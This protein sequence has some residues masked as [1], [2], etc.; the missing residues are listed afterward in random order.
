MSKEKI[1]EEEISTQ[2]EV[3]EEVQ[4]T[5]TEEAAS[6]EE[7]DERDS[8]IEELEQELANTK[9][10]LLRKAAEL[11]NVRKR[12]QRE[13]VQLFEEAKAG[14]LEDFMP[15]SDDLLRTLKAA[16]ESEIENSFLEGVQMVSDKFQNVLQKHGVERI[17]DTGVPFDVNLHDAMMKQPAPDEKTGSDVVLQVIENGYKIGNRTVRHAKVIVSE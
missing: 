4:D 12:V 10:G 5:N 16:E 3:A 6:E 13:R 9:D 7:K 1:S 8:R 14:A 2:E 17:D 11:D 15:I